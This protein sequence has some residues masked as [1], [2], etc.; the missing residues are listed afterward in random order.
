MRLLASVGHGR[1]VFTQRALPAIRPVNH[2]VDAG[3]VIVR[4]RL[5]ANVATAVRTSTDSRVVVAYEA[6]ELDPQRRTGWSVVVTGLATTITNPEQIA[7]YEQLLQ[8]WVNMA[9]DTVIAIQPEVITGIRI[10]EDRHEMT[11]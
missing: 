2:L 3:R 9:M 7:R 1:V 8:P 5:T 11:E 6:D 10:V 4:T